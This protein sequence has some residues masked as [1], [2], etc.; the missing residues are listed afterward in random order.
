MSSQVFLVLAIA[1]IVCA[2]GVGEAVRWFES[3]LLKQELL[4]QTEQAATLI[5]A[6]VTSATISGD[7]ALVQNIV[8]HASSAIPEI[9]FVDVFDAQG[10][11]FVHW[12]KANA[13]H[14]ERHVIL[15][16][17]I[18][19]GGQKFGAVKIQWDLSHADKHIDEHVLLVQL[20]VVGG[21]VLLSL[22]FFVATQLLVGKPL[23]IVHRRLLSAASGHGYDAAPLPGST[24]RELVDVGETA[25]QLAELLR[26]RK[27]FESNLSAARQQLVDAIESL[28][29]GFAIFDADDRLVICN[30]NFRNLYDISADLVQPGE[31]FEDIIRE[32]ARRGQLK[33][34]KDDSNKI[35]EW[36]AHRMEQHRNP[37]GSIEQQLSNGKWIRVE[38]RK[39]SNGGIVGLRVD[40][41]ELKKR[42]HE[43]GDAK[44]KAE[45]ANRAKSQFLAMMSHE[46]RTPLNAVLG[47]FGLL[48]DT[49]LNA[50]QD[51]YTDTGRRSA[52]ALLDLINDIL[53]FSKMEAGKL[54]LEVAPFELKEIIETVQDVVGSRAQ[55]QGIFVE[56][57]IDP[58]TPR[59][60]NGDAGR[61]RQVLLNLVG[62]AVKFTNEGGVTIKVSPQA[63]T[64][65][66]VTLYFEVI[67]TGIGIDMQHHDKLFAEFMTLN[68][69]YTQKFNGTGLGLAISKK[70]L[71][72]MGGEIDFTSQPG[73]GSRFWFSLTLPVLTESDFEEY[74]H[75][76]PDQNKVVASSVYGRIL[77][78]EDNPANQMITRVLLEKAGHKADV[79]AN[80]IEAVAAVQ[81]RSYD[82]VLMDVGMPEMG[83]V[84][85][86]R[87][88]RKIAGPRAKV[89]I[90]AM[91]AHVMRGDRESLLSA[92]MD[93][94]LAKPASKL[95]LLQMVAKWLS[96]AS[97]DVEHAP[98]ATPMDDESNAIVDHAVLKQMAEDTDPSMMPELISIFITQARERFAAILEAAEANDITRV[99]DEAH[100][101]KSSA[102][103]FGVMRLHQL[104]RD[105]EA[106]GK[107]Q[108]ATFIAQNAPNITA[109][110]EAAIAGLEDFLKQS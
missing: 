84:E 69:A 79:V 47:V 46:I 60:L 16:N 64:Q 37:S 3:R 55:E 94:Y 26:E 80:G 65:D 68:P 33:E 5:S 75:H 13:E 53:D 105:L 40:I 12:E 20:Y 101:L 109:E 14:P 71:D 107:A 66:G 8:E 28:S 22:I 99:E 102:A 103:T 76:S 63:E 81:R 45:I 85:A 49:P 92:G 32:G 48:G 98:T 35:E 88:I 24:A 72:M 10:A 21:T 11:T 91:T 54:E 51:K 96:A 73:E 30:Q 83:G 36:V 82:L 50:E 95:Q 17:D 104:A 27:L 1:A 70:L 89:P 52:E 56:A 31:R 2:V 57:I 19:S 93:D 42:Q 97:V 4:V 41:T 100:A 67:D 77:V 90:V 7:Q 61:L 44:E 38:E 29:D 9:H 106:A 43:L 25:Q 74:D 62:N 78:A 15:D 108:D 39:T 59:F 23:R 110:G 6:A 18:V 86:T 87:E 34:T 58:D